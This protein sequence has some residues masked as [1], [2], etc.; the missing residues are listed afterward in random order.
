MSD[1]NLILCGTYIPYIQFPQGANGN[2]CGFVH[3]IIC[4]PIIH[5]GIRAEYNNISSAGNLSKMAT[6]NKACTCLLS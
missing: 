5:R 2:L 3:A 6:K 1:L 4:C